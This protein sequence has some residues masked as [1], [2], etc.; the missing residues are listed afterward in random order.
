MSDLVNKKCVPCEGGVSAFDINE[1][2]KYQKK[3]DG[4]EVKKNENEK[5][6]LEKEFKFKD[7]INSQNDDSIINLLD[8][9]A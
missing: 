6:F 8:E 4:W 3:V 2:H 5:Y 1:I 7:F 9:I